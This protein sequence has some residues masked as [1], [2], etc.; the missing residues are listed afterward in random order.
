MVDRTQKLEAI[1]NFT[2]MVG[3]D[4]AFAYLMGFLAGQVD[5]VHFVRDPAGADISLRLSQAKLTVW[6][7]EP[8]RAMVGG[9]IVPNPIA[10]VAAVNNSDKPICVSLNFERSDEA[11]WYRQVLLPDVSYVADTTKAAEEE[12]TALRAE[13][14]RALDIYAECKKLLE[15]DQGERKKELDYYMTVAQEQMRQ[16]SSKLEQVNAQ[17]KRMKA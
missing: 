17:L 12:A 15:T 16:L 10:F 3:N 5:R 2:V 6:P 7:A 8:F 1:N 4:P 11:P 13:M 9:V 14:D